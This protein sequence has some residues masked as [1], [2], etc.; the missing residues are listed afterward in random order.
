MQKFLFVYFQCNCAIG[1]D[2]AKVI[3]EEGGGKEVQCW[4]SA[5]TNDSCIQY[6]LLQ[7]VLVTSHASLPSVLQVSL[8]LIKHQQSERIHLIA[9]IQSAYEGLVRPR[10]HYLT[11]IWLPCQQ[12]GLF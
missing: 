3:V 6:V 4:R 7:I 9:C 5:R 8:S 2:V 11:L 1:I 12:Q 10:I